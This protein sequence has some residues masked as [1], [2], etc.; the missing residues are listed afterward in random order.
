MEIALKEKDSQ[1]AKARSLLV[2]QIN[3]KEGA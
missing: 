3:S 2:R 1:R